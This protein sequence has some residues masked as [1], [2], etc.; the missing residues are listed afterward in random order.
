[1]IEMICCLLGSKNLGSMWDDVGKAMENE[2]EIEI[3]EV[4]CGTDKAVCTKADI[5]SYPTFKV[6]YDGEEVA[7]YQGNLSFCKIYGFIG[8]Y[9]IVLLKII[10]I[11]SCGTKFS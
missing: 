9:S 2:D 11:L 8:C 10:T 7:K 1:M 5:H 3:G 6:F 4:D